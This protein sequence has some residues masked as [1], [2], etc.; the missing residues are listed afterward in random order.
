VDFALAHG[1]YALLLA[2]L[3]AAGLGVPLP[4]DVVLLAGGVLAHRG[5]TSLPGTLA[6]CAAGVLGGDV[7]LFLWA[8]RLGESAYTLPAVARLLPPARRARVE[9]LFTRH[10]GRIVFVA[11][12]LAGL[13]APV[14]AV[15]G[16]HGL[17]LGRFLFWDAL[18]LCVSAPA[19]VGLGYLFS[20]RIDRIRG[21]LSRAEH[22]ALLLFVLGFAVYAAR[23]AWRQQRR[24]G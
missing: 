16:I 22:W 15:A 10:G 3:L 13:R 21:D 6:V 7:L 23:T 5:V 12:H 19:V 18:G 24:E 9:R 8:R 4:E 2:A 11:R 20:D 1:S 14:F 17:P